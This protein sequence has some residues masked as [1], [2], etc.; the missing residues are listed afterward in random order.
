MA[1]KR[2]AGIISIPLNCSVSKKRMLTPVRHNE[3]K[4][5]LF[6]LGALVNQHIHNTRY[7]CHHC[8]VYFKFSDIVVDYFLLGLVQHIP[9][10]VN[11][12]IVDKNGMYRVGEMEKEEKS[13]RGKKRSEES[14]GIK[15]I[16]SETFVKQEPGVFPD[17]HGRIPFS[18]MTMPGSVPPDWSRLQSPTF[19][20]NSPSKIQLGPAT[21]A[22]PGL[23]LQ[24]PASAG[25][26][27]NMSSPRQTMLPLP[28]PMMHHPEPV[29]AGSAPYTPE[30]VKGDKLDALMQIPPPELYPK[31]KV[32]IMHDE[33]LVSFFLKGT[34]D[35]K[36]DEIDTAIYVRSSPESEQDINDWLSGRDC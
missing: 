24:N 30:S 3:C 25:S 34:N 5:G 22:T 16:K 36:F 18:P 13:K 11:E 33:R 8:N 2:Q 27:L 17:M 35:V 10:G 19:S 6:D 26:M 1:A 31:G 28:H 20:M 21:P 9:M 14:N 23:V 15:R 32:V 4:K 12:L 7:L 29:I